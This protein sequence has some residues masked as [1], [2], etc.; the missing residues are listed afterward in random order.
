[1]VR[2]FRAALFWSHLLVPFGFRI[3]KA[4]AGPFRAHLSVRALLAHLVKARDS[5]LSVRALFARDRG[6]PDGAR[7]AFVHTCAPFIVRLTRAAAARALAARLYKR[8]V[9]HV[10][11]LTRDAR[12]TYT[13]VGGRAAV[14]PRCAVRLGDAHERAGPRDHGERERERGGTGAHRPWPWP[15][16]CVGRWCRCRRRFEEGGGRGCLQNYFNFKK[17]WKGKKD[18]REGSIFRYLEV[19][20]SMTISS[21]SIIGLSTVAELRTD[22]PSLLL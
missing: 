12:A 21:Q 16:F 17:K 11:G 9:Q 19:Q 3:G 15:I 8:S 6:F 18:G 2:A 20:Y 1:M 5:V 22:R 10:V 4:R 14:F 7:R 13:A